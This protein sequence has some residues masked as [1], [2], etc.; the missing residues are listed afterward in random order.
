VCYSQH[1][2]RVDQVLVN[3][4]Q[5]TL[6]A[7]APAL[8]AALGEQQ[9]GRLAA[10]LDDNLLRLVEGVAPTTMPS[11]ARWPVTL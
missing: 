7:M 8:L 3:G 11:P 1:T 6:M 2:E 10:A 4:W 9:A 5:H